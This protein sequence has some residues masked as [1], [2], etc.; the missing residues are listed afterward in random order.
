[1]SILD[2]RYFNNSYEKY[3]TISFLFKNRYVTLKFR[4]RYIIAHEFLTNNRKLLNMGA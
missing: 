3:S 2:S 1:M 4:K